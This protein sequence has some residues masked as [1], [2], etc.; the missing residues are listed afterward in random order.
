MSSPYI[1]TTGF[2]TEPAFIQK[3]NS[4]AVIPNK[5]YTN[6]IPYI[7]TLCSRTDN[8]AEDDFGAINEFGTGLIIT[9]PKGF[10]FELSGTT[11]L[12]KHGY[13][14]EG[15]HIVDASTKELIVFL[16]KFK[17]CEDLE[18]PFE[19]VNMILRPNY[20]VH[21]VY[22]PSS[23]SQTQEETFPPN[24]PNSKTTKGPQKLGKKSNGFY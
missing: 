1:S 9:P 15:P 5:E 2:V 17:E 11:T 14:F 23:T 7:I 4:S 21:L 22:A 20:P 8:R 18:L 10:H 3:T 6:S 13:T 19:C 24:Y 12:L 16:H